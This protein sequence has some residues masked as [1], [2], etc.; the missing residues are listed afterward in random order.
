MESLESLLKQNEELQL[1][2]RKLHKYVSPKIL[3]TLNESKLVELQA[4]IYPMKV[5]KLKTILAEH[6]L[7]WYWLTDPSAD[8]LALERLRG[9]A[10]QLL[11]EGLKA[12]TMVDKESI[13]LL[14][15]KVGIAKTILSLS[16][17]KSERRGEL[18]PKELLLALPKNFRDMSPEEIEQEA[19][20]VERENDW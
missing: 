3:A 9:E 19:S 7:L 6:P 18:T 10:M 5:S 4:Y 17:V 12:S 14:K 16:E 20:R 2:R 13:L 1:V 11:E 15:E 8:M